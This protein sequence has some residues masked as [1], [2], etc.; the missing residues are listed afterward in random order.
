[1]PRQ[2]EL[3]KALE[4]LTAEIRR[5]NDRNEPVAVTVSKEAD[6]GRARYDETEREREA[7]EELEAALR[8]APRFG[9]RPP[10]RPDS[11]RS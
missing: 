11:R 2:S 3:V 10:L 5:Y 9:G 7:R 6:F 1:M 4:R 8:Q